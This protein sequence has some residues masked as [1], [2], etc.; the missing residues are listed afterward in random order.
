MLHLREALTEARP[1]QKELPELVRILQDLT[2]RVPQ[3]LPFQ[4]PAVLSR[5]LAEDHLLLEDLDP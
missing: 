4:V 5:F 2:V 3:H 1:K